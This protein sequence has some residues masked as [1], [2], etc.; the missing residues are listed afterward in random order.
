ST[1]QANVWAIVA[2]EHAFRSREGTPPDF[3]ARAWI[4]NRLVSS[5]D[6][7]GV[8]T[9]AHASVVPLADG[10]FGSH[11]GTP[12]PSGM[13]LLRYRLGVRYAVDWSHLPAVERGL[14]VDRQY[15]PLDDPDD[16]RRDAAGAW[17]I[18]AGARVRVRLALV[19]PV[20]RDQVALV[21]PLA[22]GLE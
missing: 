4:G 16:V 3:T 13:G 1:T 7:H 22:A 14:S 20:R 2:L 5:A 17:H 11:E 19:A 9:N 12:A 15:E 6:F 10:R 8:Q 21:S 18:R